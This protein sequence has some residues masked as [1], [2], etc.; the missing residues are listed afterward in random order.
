MVPGLLLSKWNTVGFNSCLR[1]GSLA[2]KI[3]DIITIIFKL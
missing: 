2:I 1:F 3:C